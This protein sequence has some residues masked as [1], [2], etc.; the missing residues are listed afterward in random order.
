MNSLA[1]VNLTPELI[2]MFIENT[3]IAYV[4]L[5][6]NRRIHYINKSFLELRKLD[7][8]TTVGEYCYNIS[9]GGV[10]CPEC[11]VEKSI[12]S[13]KA[14][15]ISRKDKLPDG[16][17]KFIDDY[18]IP[19]EDISEDEHQ[20]TLEIMVNRSVEM[21]FK[22]KRNKD[23]ESLVTVMSKLLESKDTYTAE[24]SDNVHTIAYHIACAMNL[25][26]EEIYNISLAAKLHDIGKVG[27][28]NSIINKASRL[29]DEEFELI[30]SHAIKSYE[31]LKNLES[32]KDIAQIVKQHHERIDGKGYPDGLK[33]DEILLG[34]R[35]VAV[36]DTFEAMTSDRSYRKALSAETAIA[37][38]KRVAGTQLDAEV[39][40][41]FESLHF[42]YNTYKPASTAKDINDDELKVIN[43]VLKKPSIKTDKSDWSLKQ[44]KKLDKN[45]ILKEIFENTPCGYV[46]MKPDHTVLYASPYFL[47]YMGLKK[48]NVL[49]KKCYTI[50]DKNATSC[51]ECA[52]KESIKVDKPYKIRREQMTNNGMKTFDMYG[53]P[54][55]NEFGIIEYLIEVILDR[56]EEANL[57]KARINDYRNLFKLLTHLIKIKGV[58]ED[59]KE[60]LAKIPELQLKLAQLFKE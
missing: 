51:E 16:S 20:Y 15:F 2:E 9:N 41:I 25:S 33:G 39:V 54:L 3:P 13:R 43:R 45:K 28:P 52:V 29:T 18:A 56:T 22:E 10:P 34:A 55:K 38:M 44:L 59:D 46:L 40:R 12:I 21:Q 17:T 19:L 37:E 36:A 5:D 11:A 47:N 48:E 53:I 31:M 49:E 24:H 4:I 7:W 35:I 27:I 42:D 8:N 1:N 50:A 58:D 23:F 6:E 57:E 30:K 32:F 60:M 14:S 26:E